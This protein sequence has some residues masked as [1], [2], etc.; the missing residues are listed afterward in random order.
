MFYVYILQSQKDDEL[1]TGCTTNL[2]KRLKDHNEGLVYS[3]KSKRPYKL[4]HYEFFL[5]KKDAFVREKWLKTGWGRNQV[6][7]MLE[8]YF[9]DISAKTF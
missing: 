8:N 5:N 4:I 3:T 2:T 9:G 1:Y 6:K 7:K